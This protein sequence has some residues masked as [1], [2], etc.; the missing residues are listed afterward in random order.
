MR[1]SLRYKLLGLA[2]ATSS[3]GATRPFARPAAEAHQPLW[4]IGLIIGIVCFLSVLAA[5]NCQAQP[6]IG[7][8]IKGGIRASNDLDSD[9][10]ESE[11]KRYTVG[12]MI[13]FA[14]PFRLGVE[15]DGLYRRT[16]F[17]TTFYGIG[18]VS[19]SRYR[20]NTWEFPMLLKYRLPRFIAQPYIEAGYAPRYISGSYTSV[21]A[22]QDLSTGA[23]SYGS[24]RGD[25]KPAVTHGFVTGVG[26]EAG[27]RH[28]RVA[29][30]FRYTRWNRD[31]I[32][33][34]GPH[35]YSVHATQN[36]AEVMIGILWR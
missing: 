34:F 5:G 20:A 14:L 9:W 24:S 29:P 17:R 7:F 33:F 6:R 26:I 1:L 21:G 3:P 23:T 28:V 8:G 16:G 32:D 2:V 36:Q 10:A 27:G 30:E 22:S 13:D 35:G 4:R 12:P 25:W 31:P 18:S 11:S 15:V 19:F